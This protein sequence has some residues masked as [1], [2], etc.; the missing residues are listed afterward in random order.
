MD[1]AAADGVGVNAAGV[2]G[3][4]FNAVDGAVGVD[5]TG[6]RSKITT[7]AECVSSMMSTTATNPVP[8]V[9]VLRYSRI[10]PCGASNTAAAA[11]VV[12]VA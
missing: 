8:Y 1:G 9:S 5:G 2:D 3:V 4:G 7:R 12:R 6:M 10:G 11:S